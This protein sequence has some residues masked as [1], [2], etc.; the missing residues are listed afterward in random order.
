MGNPFFKAPFIQTKRSKKIQNNKYIGIC[1]KTAFINN[2]GPREVPKLGNLHF[3]LHAFSGWGTSRGPLLMLIHTSEISI[4]QAHQ[5]RC[6]DTPLLMMIHMPSGAVSTLSV[7][8]YRHYR[9]IADTHL[10]RK[11]VNLISLVA[12]KIQEKYDLNYLNI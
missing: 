6:M 10:L 3:H 12:Q 4:C 1:V 8:S 9:T 7:R 5:S 11:C 2:F